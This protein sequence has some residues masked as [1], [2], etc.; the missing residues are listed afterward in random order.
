MRSWAAAGALHVAG[1]GQLRPLRA[2]PELRR[3]LRARVG[4]PRRRPG[5]PRAPCRARRARARGARR[6]AGSRRTPRARSPPARCSPARSRS[7][8]GPRA[9]GSSTRSR[10]RP[11]AA[12]G[13]GGER[14][15]LGRHGDGRP[16]APGRSR[17][18]PDR[19][20]LLRRLAAAALAERPPTGFL[21]DFVLHPSGERKGVLDIK[22]RGL[23]R[24]S[25][26]RAGA[27]SRRA[28]ARPRRAPA[29]R[30]PRR[31]GRSAR[32]TRRTC[33]TRSSWS[34]RCAWSTRWSSCATGAPPDDLIEP[35]SLAPLARDPR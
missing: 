22:R 28:S 30:P 9:P 1:H 29:W 5:D 6:S 33:A 34:A 3:R 13:G 10:P 2:V 17:E 19:K 21:R 31:P 26:S 15:G 4:G 11:D 18:A 12:L 32:T 24:S 8:S 14:S 20:L 25:R 7:G 16:S 27:A 35:K 23:L